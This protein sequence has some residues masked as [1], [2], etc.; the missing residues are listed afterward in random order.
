MASSSLSLWDGGTRHLAQFLHLWAAFGWVVVSLPLHGNFRTQADENETP[1]ST[2]L[3]CNHK[4]IKSRAQKS[5][6]YLADDLS[7]TCVTLLRPAIWWCFIALRFSAPRCSVSQSS[8]QFLWCYYNELMF[9]CQ[10]AIHFSLLIAQKRFCMFSSNST[11]QS[12]D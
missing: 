9:V 7:Q 4:T 5:N 12:I 11:I 6:P 2:F 1:P 3:N 10:Q 8:M